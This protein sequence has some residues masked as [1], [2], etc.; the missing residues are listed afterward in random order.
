M[1]SP[2]DLLFEYFLTSTDLV[3]TIPDPNK[4]ILE[5]NKK[6]L[7]RMIR[8]DSY[9]P[10]F[11]AEKIKF[12]KNFSSAY[13]ELR[14][15]ANE[16][17]NELNVQTNLP[18]SYNV[19]ITLQL[20]ILETWR[21]VVVEKVVFN[22]RVNIIKGKLD[23]SPYTL[24]ILYKFVV[25]SKFASN[26]NEMVKL[27]QKLLESPKNREILP[28]IYAEIKRL[29]DYSTSEEVKKNKGQQR[30]AYTMYNTLFAPLVFSY[31]L[32]G[33]NLVRYYKKI[34]KQNQLSYTSTVLMDLLGAYSFRMIYGY[35]N[36]TLVSLAEEL[37]QYFKVI[38][39]T[40]SSKE[41]KSVL[42]EGSLYSYL[43]TKANEHNITDMNKISLLWNLINDIIIAALVS[44]ELYEEDDEVKKAYKEKIGEIDIYEYTTRQYGLAY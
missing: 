22:K 14:N 6:E 37:S 12:I 31:T 18:P 8:E 13:N 25:I 5:S 28:D 9:I 4:T 42:K 11:S 41:F 33:S 16:I 10:L 36:S 21:K 32:S 15:K 35:S 3:E 17:L 7:L 23:I 44:L 34:S 43:V 19:A 24:L 1:T 2:S 27:L 20:A 29:I 38:H 26:G 40:L 30:R 39:E